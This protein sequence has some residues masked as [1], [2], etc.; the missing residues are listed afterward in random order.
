MV[1]IVH[2][3]LVGLGGA[4]VL[5]ACGQPEAGVG[6]MLGSVVPNLDAGLMVLGRDRYLR[7]HQGATHSL[8][9]IPFLATF[10]AFVVSGVARIDGL[11]VLLG[12]MGGMALH[13]ALDAL[14]T[15]GVRLLWPFRPRVAL[16]AFCF[17]DLPTLAMT[18]AALAALGTVAGEAVPSLA[19]AGGWLLGVAA[20]AGARLAWAR[21]V[22]AM[23]GATHIVPDGID[24]LRAYLAWSGDGCVETAYAR[25]LRA[26]VGGRT[27]VGLPP[28]GTSALCRTSPTFAR[29][30]ESLKLFV[31]VSL[32]EAEGVTTVVSRCMA[33]RNFG[34]R[35]GELTQRFV[36]GR[37]VGEHARL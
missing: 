3:A 8:L 18:A 27:A 37:L 22:R 31:P 32:T 36:E 30:E 24:P 26:R 28:P 29:L 33:V 20:Y 16:D 23:T 25:G 35:Y 9:V 10:L 7:L 17:V 15:F 6:L 19:V 34:N 11:P 13:V 14:N 1:D 12:A 4:L 5:G 21:R 2:H